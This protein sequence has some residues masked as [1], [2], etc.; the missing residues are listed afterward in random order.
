VLRA[1][2]EPLGALRPDLPAR[3]VDAVTRGLAR[4]S[5]DRFASA[6][7]L[8]E[9]L[10]DEPHSGVASQ[11]AA[12]VRKLCGQQLDELQELTHGLELGEHTPSVASPNSATVEVTAVRRRRYALAGAAS[13][14]CV[15]LGGLLL[16][17]LLRSHREP[18]ATAPASGPAAAAALSPAPVPPAPAE[19][20][21]VAEVA[22]DASKPAVR[23]AP[24]RATG[25]LTVDARPWA[26]VMLGTRVLG[27]T[28][29]DRVP[30]PAGEWALTLE[31]PKTQKTVRKRVKVIAGKT[32]FVKEDL[33]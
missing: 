12:H 10:G 6:L 18:G 22:D 16:L 28:P 21:P 23:A 1:E 11:L 2:L 14:A 13:F 30:V 7:E 17:P 33:R 31:N 9:A 4:K 29:M 20:E 24:V 27:E 5:D 19:P 8:R 26:K 15:V 32:V 3:F 25:F